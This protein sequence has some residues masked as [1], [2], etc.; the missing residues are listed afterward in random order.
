[1]KTEA[2]NICLCVAVLGMAA[3]MFSIAYRIF[4]GGFLCH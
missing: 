2:M 1:M 4:T 3:V